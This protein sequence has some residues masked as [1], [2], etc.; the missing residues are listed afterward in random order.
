M[1]FTS[2]FSTPAWIAAPTATTSSGF[3]P[4]CGSLPPVSFFTS[5]WIIG[6]RVEPPTR[7][8]WSI[9]PASLPQSLTACS[10]GRLAPLD[11]VLG[12]ALELRRG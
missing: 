11:Q 8:T 4:L 7:I 2:P 9:A 5:S 3:T 10:N 1:S 6:I 12:H